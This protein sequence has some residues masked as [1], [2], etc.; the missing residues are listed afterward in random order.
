MDAPNGS[1]KRV[2]GMKRPILFKVAALGVPGGVARKEA[3][4]E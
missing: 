1:Y 2:Q 4:N 3:K